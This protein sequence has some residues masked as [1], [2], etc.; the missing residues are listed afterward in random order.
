MSQS[1][2]EVIAGDQYTTTPAYEYPEGLGTGDYPHFILFTAR[3]A[4]TSTVP[5]QSTG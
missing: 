2:A 5:A 3:R 4:Y 1:V